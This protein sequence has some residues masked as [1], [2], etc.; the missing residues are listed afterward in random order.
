MKATL[1]K[2]RSGKSPSSPDAFDAGFWRNRFPSEPYA[3]D[4][5]SF[6]DYEP[7]YRLGHSLRDTIGDFDLHEADIRERWHA[8]KGGSRLSWERAKDAVRSAWEDNTSMPHVEGD[9]S[10]SD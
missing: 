9:P 1:E 10:A 8:S 7:A 4:T 3:V 6:E 2:T 5:D